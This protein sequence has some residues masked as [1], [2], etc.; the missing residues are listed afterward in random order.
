MTDS[1]GNA[2]K[3]SSPVRSPQDAAAGLFLIGIAALAL[4]QTTELAMG[5]LRSFGPG[6][7]PRAL[8]VILG[9]SGVAL[10]VSSFLK[11]GSALERWSLRGPVFI[12]GSILLFAFTIRNFGLVVAGP[13]AMIAGAYASPE[14]RFKETAIF[15]VVLTAVCIVLFNVLLRLPIPILK[16]PT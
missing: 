7:L 4:W 15:A 3:R 12:L 8:A 6:M 1:T 2:E 9:G 11:D 10:I 13:L 5:T 16:L 14:A